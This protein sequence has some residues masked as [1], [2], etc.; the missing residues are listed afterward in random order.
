MKLMKTTVSGAERK[1]IIKI[2]VQ[3]TYNVISAKQGHIIP[4]HVTAIKTLS[5]HTQ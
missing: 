4:L 2:T 3:P 1:D 5:G